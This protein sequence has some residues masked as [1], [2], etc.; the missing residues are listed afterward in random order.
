MSGNA[1]LEQPF[2]YAAITDLYF[3]TAFLPDTPERATVVTLHNTID[4]PSDLS[5]PNSK[6]KPP[7]V[8]GLAMG[9]T[10]GDTRLRLFAGPKATGCAELHSR[11]R[12]GWQGR[13][14]NRWNR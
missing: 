11:H 14:A 5:D 7:H 9:D 10:S 12:P 6:K 13:P 4:L 3:A 8:L 1:T 2:E